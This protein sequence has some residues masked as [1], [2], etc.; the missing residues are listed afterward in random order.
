M[1]ED[2]MKILAVIFLLV[3]ALSSCGTTSGC[4]KD[5]PQKTSKCCKH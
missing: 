5:V 3:F 4:I 2:T 1:E